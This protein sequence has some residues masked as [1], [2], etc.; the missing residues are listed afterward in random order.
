[1]GSEKKAGKT[2]E[3]EG[4]IPHVNRWRER[5]A[6]GFRFYALLGAAGLAI[7][8]CGLEEYVFLYPPDTSLSGDILSFN[9]NTENDP[10][11]F[12]GYRILYRFFASTSAVDT[13]IASV[14]SLYTSS[15]TT[16]Y[17]KMK[18]SPHYFRDM[19]IGDD[20]RDELIIQAADRQDSFTVELNFQNSVS[21]GGDATII[22]SVGSP[23]T[24]PDI[25]SVVVVYQSI[26][27]EAKVGFTQADLVYRDGYFEDGD[28]YGDQYYAG[29]TY[30]LLYVMAYGY[31]SSF[32]NVYSEPKKFVGTTN[33]LILNVL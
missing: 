33:Y 4:V 6:A 11:V 27:G 28:Q 31:N 24:T 21:S 15:P 16:I 9:N 1:M 32:G 7:S 23:V 8:S 26:S 17:R 13:A 5:L 3:G 12:Y 14:S 25:S 19:K 20:E 18:E 2:I 22:L 10:T 30:L 29:K